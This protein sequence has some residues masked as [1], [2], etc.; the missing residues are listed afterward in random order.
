MSFVR[1]VLQTLLVAALL[2]LFIRTFLFQAYRIP[3]SSM[4]PGL[5][6]G[7]QVVVNKVIFGP[8]RWAWE[9]RFLP[10]RAVQK[11]DLLVFRYPRDLRA[12]FI[13]RVVALGRREG[14]DP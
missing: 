9:S 13:K 6:V 2:G 8:T 10:T 12:F 11:N 1:R 7:D 3:S 5:E 14:G 4:E